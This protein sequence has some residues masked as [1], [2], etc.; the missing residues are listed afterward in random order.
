VDLPL[1]FD[2]VP[3]YRDCTVAMDSDAG[4]IFQNQKKY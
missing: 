1:C 3:R 4:K 2:V